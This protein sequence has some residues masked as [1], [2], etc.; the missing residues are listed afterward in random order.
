MIQFNPV[1]LHTNSSTMKNQANPSFG[2]RT[3]APKKNLDLVKYYSALEKINER[4]FPPLSPAEEITNK[5]R[6]DLYEQALDSF[7][8]VTGNSA[9]RKPE[10]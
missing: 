9:L 8:V 7:G 5:Y 10:K 6:A 1:K 4:H 3:I 2:T